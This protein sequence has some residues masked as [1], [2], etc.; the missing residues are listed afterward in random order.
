MLIILMTKHLQIMKYHC[1]GPVKSKQAHDDMWH[2][3]ML[4]KYAWSKKLYIYIFQ[5]YIKY[6]IF[7]SSKSTTIIFDNQT[8]I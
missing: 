6:F 3:T 7:H 1:S 8:I 5:L 4:K 2:Q